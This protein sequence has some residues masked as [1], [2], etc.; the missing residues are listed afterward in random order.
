MKNTIKIKIERNGETA[1]IKVLIKHPMET[2]RR[3]DRQ[4]NKLIPAHFIREVKCEHN[5][6]LV[7]D[8]IWGVAISRNPYLSFTVDNTKKGDVVGISWKDNLG[9]SD[10]KTVTIS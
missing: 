9:D 10:A 3:K 4:S 2:G 8:A 7:L 1:E 5:N 6:N